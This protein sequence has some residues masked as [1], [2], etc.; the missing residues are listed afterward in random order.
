M[1][2]ARVFISCGQRNDREKKIGFEV[3]DFFKNKGF[4]TY[5]AERVHSPEALTENIFS[6]LKASEYF[7]FIDFKREKLDDNNHRGSLFVNQ[8]LAIATYLKIPNL[9]FHEHGVVREGIANYQIY[10]TISFKD[11]NDILDHLKVETQNWD[12]NS[13]NELLI[14]FDPQFEC[15]GKFLCARFRDLVCGELLLLS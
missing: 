11:V 4:I 14:D 5:F 2:K 8:E 15:G 13:V 9:G 7:V 12:V 6:N 1:R 3:E 10:N